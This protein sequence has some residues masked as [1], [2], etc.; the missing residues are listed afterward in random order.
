M[1]CDVS[2]QPQYAQLHLIAPDSCVSALPVLECKSRKAVVRSNFLE[3]SM[4]QAQLPVRIADEAL[5]S[6][7]IPLDNEALK[8]V[9]GGMT[10]D[11]IPQSVVT[12]T[13]PTW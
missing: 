6:G 7:P 12:V 10:S 13:D 8:Q 4:Q 5:V 2:G 1:H 11:P 9:V 3:N